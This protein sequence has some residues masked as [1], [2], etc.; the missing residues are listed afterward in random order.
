[1]SQVPPPVPPVTPQAPV[2]SP[3]EFLGQSLPGMPSMPPEFSGVRPVNVMNNAPA[4]PA[5]N[6]VA[7]YACYFN[8]DRVLKVDV[9]NT[10]S[11]F[12]VIAYLSDPS[13]GGDSSGRQGSFA[14]L[15]EP[16][17]DEAEAIAAC[18]RI[19]AALASPATAA[20]WPATMPLA[21]R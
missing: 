15:S 20:R 9:S 6:L 12:R 11:S 16:F 17:D 4:R 8:P 10:G 1:M 3:P 14:F 13:P 19:V 5:L 18:D 7:G 2:G 21:A